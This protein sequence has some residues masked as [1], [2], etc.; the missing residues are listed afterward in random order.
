MFKQQPDKT[1][2]DCEKQAHTNNI[3]QVTG[4]TNP[5]PG[6]PGVAGGN[7]G[8]GGNAGKA[9]TVPSVTLNSVTFS[10]VREK[11]KMLIIKLSIITITFLEAKVKNIKLSF[12][13]LIIYRKL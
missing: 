6:S 12:D 10:L 4:C 8:D 13:C 1:E 9:G 7:G 5:I 3:G 11:I 2:R